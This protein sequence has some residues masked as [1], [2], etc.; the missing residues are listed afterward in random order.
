MRKKIARLMAAGMMVLIAG[1]S[2]ESDL[3]RIDVEHFEENQ[4]VGGTATIVKK[5]RLRH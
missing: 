4:L 5:K 3:T 2:E 1:C